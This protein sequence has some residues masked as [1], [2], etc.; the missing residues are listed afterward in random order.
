MVL[1]TGTR[2]G[3]YEVLAPIGAG[4]MGEVYRARDTR[5][6]REVAIKVLLRA[7][8]DDPDRLLRFQREAELLAAVNHP[9]IAAIYGVEEVDGIKALVLELVEGPTLADRLTRGPIPLHEALAIGRQVVDALD[10]AHD[11]GIIHRDL[12]PANLKVREDGAV[13]VLD[14]GLAKGREAETTPVDATTAPTLTNAAMTR[15]GVVLGTAAYMSPEQARGQ[16]IDKRTDVWAFGCVLY[17]MLA[18]RP[19]FPGATVADI[20]AAVLEREPD[21]K[22]LPSTLPSTVGRLLRRCL[23]KDPR[24]RLRDI[25][26][27]QADLDE[28]AWAPAVAVTGWL[29]SRTAAR[30]FAVSAAALAIVLTITAVLIL[31]LARDAPTLQ[32]TVR[33]TLVPPVEQPLSLSQADRDFVISRDGTRLVYVSGDGALMV[34]AIDRLDAVRLGNI[35]GARHPFLSPDGQWVGFFEGVSETELKKVSITGG[36]AISLCRAPGGGRGAAWGADDTIVFATTAGRLLTVAASGGEPRVISTPDTARGETGHTYPSLL[37]GGQTVLVTVTSAGNS[38]D[39]AQ[40][41]ALDVKTGR[42]QILINGGSQAQYV[43]TGHL[44]YGTGGALR[45][46]RFNAATLE[47]MGDPVTVAD[48]VTTIAST[49]AVEYSLSESGA[50]V[51]LAGGVVGASRSLVWVD[52]EGRE[53]RVN[54]PPR[55]YVYTD[56]SPD[57]SRVALDV[58]DQ[59]QDI[60]I[61]DFAR[62]TL[63]RLTADPAF[64]MFPVWTGD[65][66]RVVF[67]SRRS[68]RP[69]SLFWQ[70]AD[71]TGNREPLASPSTGQPT[72]LSMF[73]DDARLLVWEGGHLGVLRVGRAAP[74]AGAAPREVEPLAGTPF[75]VGPRASLSPD[76]RWLAYESIGPEPQIHVR[77]FPNVDDGSWPISADGGTR[78]RWGS[79]GNE[80]FY[81]DGT[82]AMV[83]VPVQTSPRFS[84]GLP[85]KLF[86]GPYVALGSGQSYDVAPDGQR[87]LMIKDASADQV[88]TNLTVVWNWVNELRRLLPTE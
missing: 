42:R 84:A 71:G 32:P 48:R 15:R 51:Y 67:T 65:G 81:L 33:L 45:A 74:I 66:R 56:L 29:A 60:W 68:G 25:G 3:T 18:G 72:A 55:M 10:A 52:R 49:G 58:R 35:T 38:L 75:E 44:V 19:A 4:G 59:D 50:L 5:L 12:K 17:E 27:A 46:V 70:P 43:E 9:N 28:T 31:T 54:A 39:N 1:S 2:L 11:R 86:S 87:F 40:I 61:W 53:Q 47:V 6:K 77:P 36:P 34:R 88:S 83:A 20:L 22:A 62:Q 26:D 23:E 30:R 78:P 8:A 57:G 21:W 14:F 69:G 76:G 13:K 64:D 24:R 85:Q 63:T 73:P 41:A 16:A 80:L 37:P 82:G 7:W 79:R